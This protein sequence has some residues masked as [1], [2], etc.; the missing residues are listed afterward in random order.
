MFQ[1]NKGAY[2]R[3]IAQKIANSIYLRVC[4]NEGNESKNG[5][6]EEAQLLK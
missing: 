4:Y 6:S 2:A 1:M 5:I 3:T